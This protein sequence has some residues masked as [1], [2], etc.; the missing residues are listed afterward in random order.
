MLRTILEAIHREEREEKKEVLKKE[1][2]EEEKERDYVV[3][4]IQSLL[5]HYYRSLS[6]FTER[7][8]FTKL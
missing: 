8:A 3:T 6:A 5:S 2:E 4:N 1:Q 7:R